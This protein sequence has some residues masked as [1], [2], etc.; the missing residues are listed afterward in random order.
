MANTVRG[1]LRT[2]AT[3]DKR[4]SGPATDRTRRTRSRARHSNLHEGRIARSVR[5]ASDKTTRRTPGAA[6][7]YSAAEPGGAG[8]GRGETSQME[9][10]VRARWVRDAERALRV[11]STCGNRP[12]A[13]G[14]TTR[15]P[16][17]T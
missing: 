12:D 17:S 15:R 7:A 8:S 3:V 2:S 11:G 5:G 4:Q 9:W 13:S 14:E 16:H 6:E 10:G 1:L